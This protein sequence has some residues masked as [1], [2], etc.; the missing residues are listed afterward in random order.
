M[1]ITDDVIKFVPRPLTI[2]TMATKTCFHSNARRSVLIN[3][4]VLDD[5]LIALYFFQ[6]DSFRVPHLSRK[7]DIKK[8]VT[9]GRPEDRQ[10][11]REKKGPNNFSKKI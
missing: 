2:I 10:K 7:Y 11:E 3:P 4:F 6:F 5:I 1:W 8:L 9:F